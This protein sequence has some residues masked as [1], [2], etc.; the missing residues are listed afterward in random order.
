LNIW[1]WLINFNVSI[2]LTSLWT[3]SLAYSIIVLFEV[4]LNSFYFGLCSFMFLWLIISFTLSIHDSDQNDSYWSFTIFAFNPPST[5]ICSSSTL[6]IL[7]A[8]DLIRLLPKNIFKPC[9]AII[10]VGRNRPNPSISFDIYIISLGKLILKPNLL[11]N[12]AL[13]NFLNSNSSL[14]FILVIL[15]PKYLHTLLM[16]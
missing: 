13:Y 7:A 10:V 11:S 2:S 14:L 9:I 15:Y 16:S 1:T 5:H 3:Y 6:I 8:F 12:G 4:I